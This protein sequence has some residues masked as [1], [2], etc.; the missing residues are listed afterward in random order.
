MKNKRQETI[1]AIIER[2]PIET[3][4]QLIE[5]LALHG[6]VSTQATISRDIKQLHLVKQPVN[7]GRYCYAVSEQSSKLNL[8]GRL[9]TILRESIV[10]VDCARNLVV[11]KTVPG[12]AGGAGSAFDGMQI[13]AMLGSLAGNDTVLLVMRDEASAEEFCREIAKM[14]K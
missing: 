6:I 14:K 13:P 3:Q 4:E 12:L 8:S 1:L 9:H 2:E 5:R 7:G 10:S 11:L